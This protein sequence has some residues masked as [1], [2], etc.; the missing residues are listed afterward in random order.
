MA[1]ITSITSEKLQAAI[2]RLLPSQQ[3]FGEDLQASNVITP[4]IDLTSTAEG[5]DLDPS[6]Q[7]AVSYD[8]T[9]F[10]I[11]NAT[12]TTLISS[13]GFL[14]VQG[15]LGGLI[16]GANV[17]SINITDGTTSKAVWKYQNGSPV[18]AS[19]YGPLFIAFDFIVFVASGE[20]LTGTAS[21]QH[22]LTGSVRQIAD[23][24]GNLINPSGYTP[25]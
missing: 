16:S 2:R 12:G 24:N 22:F 1:Q 10:E 18:A 7:Q 3:G 20:T 14:R 19:E 17:D 9:V 8:N 15:T 4:I 6:L 13:T 25:Q 23:I 21:S 11:N 5:S